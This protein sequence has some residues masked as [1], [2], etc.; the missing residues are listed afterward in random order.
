V[1]VLLIADSFGGSKGGEKLYN[2]LLE[3]NV[4][5]CR[6]YAGADLS[7]ELSSFSSYLITQEPAW[8]RPPLSHLT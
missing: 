7:Q 4:P 1:V 3:H 5:V 6:I 8:Q 2:S